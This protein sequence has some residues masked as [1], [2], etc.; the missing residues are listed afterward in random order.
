[1]NV[2]R[3]GPFLATFHGHGAVALSTLSPMK[4]GGMNRG[5]H[6]HWLQHEKSIASATRSHQLEA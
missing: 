3:F 5:H 1:M 4:L 2:T 6:K